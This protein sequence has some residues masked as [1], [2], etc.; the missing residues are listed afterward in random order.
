MLEVCASHVSCSARGTST[1]HAREMH[2]LHQPEPLPGASLDLMQPHTHLL[3]FCNPSLRCEG[4]DL[5]PISRSIFRTSIL[6]SNTD[7][8]AA[9]TSERPA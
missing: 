5:K 1:P 8:P 6:L 3:E 9:P 2:W 4:L 7:A